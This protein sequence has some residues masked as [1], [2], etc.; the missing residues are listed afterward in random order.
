LQSLSIEPRAA[1][2]GTV[3]HTG[4][5]AWRLSIPAGPAKIYRLAQLDDYFS[6]PRARLAWRAPVTLSLRARVSTP[7]LAGTWGFGFW[8]D[9]FS[10]SFGLGG[11]ARRTPALPNTAW[12]FFA[13]PPNYLSLRNDLPADGLLAAT[14]RAARIPAPLLLLGA[15]TL[16]LLALPPAARLLRKL[17]RRF[18]SQSAA[19]L[20]IDPTHWHTYQIAWGP[21]L[22]EFR[23]DGQCLH[24]TEVS[25]HGPLGL[26]LWVDNQYAAFPPT[27]RTAFGS[28][29]NLTPTWLEIEELNISSS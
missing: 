17:A 29:P 8:N 10:A 15:T 9:P 1:G 14:F 21:A 26:V 25:P 22:T 20:E 6:L 18:L 5:D 4:E 13:S 12:F 19:R 16:P 11:M 24:R 3:H 7:D 27:G 23:V 2:G 28:L